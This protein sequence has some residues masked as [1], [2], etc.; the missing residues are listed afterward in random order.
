[1]ESL[2]KRSLGKV[3]NLQEY[4]DTASYSLM[5]YSKQLSTKTASNS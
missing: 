1:M 4:I 2:V 3:H 5:R